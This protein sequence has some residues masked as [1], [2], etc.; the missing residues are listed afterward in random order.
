[1]SLAATLEVIR[2]WLLCSDAV[3]LLASSKEINKIP[4]LRAKCTKKENVFEIEF[5]MKLHYEK[6]FKEQEANKRIVGSLILPPPLLSPGRIVVETCSSRLRV[7]INPT[8]CSWP[9][10]A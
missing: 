1:M 2:E 4:Q 10:R 3:Q 9:I 6:W 8:N 7:R 5:K